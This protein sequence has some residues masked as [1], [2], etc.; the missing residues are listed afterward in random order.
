MAVTYG[1]F[2]DVNGDRLY[3]AEQI[4]KYLQGIVSSGVYADASDSLQVMAAGGLVVTVRPGRAMLH[5]HWLEN[6]EPLGLQL[7]AGGALPRVDAVV[8]RLDMGGRRCEIAVKQG[9]PSTAPVSP[10]L[11]RTDATKEYMLAA[12]NVPALASAITQANITDTRANTALCGWVSGVIDQ[13]DTS[14]LYL[15]WQAAY[16]EAYAELGDYLAAQKAAWETFF[17]SVT[18]DNDLPA[19]ALDDAHKFVQ[20][21]RYGNGYQLAKIPAAPN[22]LLINSDFTNP[23][24]RRGLTSYSSADSGIDAWYHGN[25]QI[26]LAGGAVTVTSTNA[27][28]EGWMYQFIRDGALTAG[29][30][31]TLA[32]KLADG[33]VCAAATAALDS[34]GEGERF[35]IGNIGYLQFVKFDT[36]HP[37]GDAF[38]IVVTIGKAASIV[39]AALYEGEYTTDTL[40]EYQPKGYAAEFAAT[41]Q[42]DSVTTKP[43]GSCG[44]MLANNEYLT[45]EFFAGKPVYTMLINR[46]WEKGSVITIPFAKNLTPHK[47]CGSVG[48]WTLPFMYTG[49]LD[50]SYSAIVTVHKNNDDL[51][52][53]MYGGDSIAGTLLLQIWYCKK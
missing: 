8:M 19:P 7:A 24:N 37:T 18:E 5:Y 3:T 15:Q 39:W 28:H 22:N 23:I 20:V 32:V 13:V 21:N 30:M 46:P 16:E 42:C 1:F 4:G 43:I 50:G 12:V 31:Y 26:D 10:D 53:G 29:K 9:A 27:A 48:T 40:P 36:G 17:A 25:V 33:S 52:I 35:A 11:E 45:T 6:D 14:T 2:N 49:K 44:E 34:A 47:Y 38:K 51:K 41:A